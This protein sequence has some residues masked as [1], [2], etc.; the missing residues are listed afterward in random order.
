M[1]LWRRPFGGSYEPRTIADSI[2]VS[3]PRNANW[4]VKAIRETKGFG[5]TV[6]DKEIIL[7]IG[8]LARKTG[9]FA[10]PAASASLAGL[11]RYAGQPDGAKGRESI[12]LL[13]T[14]SGLKDIPAAQKAIKIRK[15]VEPTLPAVKKIFSAL[16]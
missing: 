1:R 10:E 5:L 4:A 6:S 7:A 3:A 9:I 15:P 12:V 13:I 14:G 11:V 2:S 8:H 16:K